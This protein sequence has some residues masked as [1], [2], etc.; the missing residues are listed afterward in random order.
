MD[1]AHR[2]VYRHMKQAGVFEAPPAMLKTISE[3]VTEVYAGQ[4]LADLEPR[5]EMERE[6]EV[7]VER[8]KKEM[9]AA[10]ASLERDI[11]KLREGKTV[12]YRMWERPSSIFGAPSYIG[13]RRIP[14]TYRD[15]SEPR[16]RQMTDN[17]LPHYLPMYEVGEGYK[18]LDFLVNYSVPGQTGTAEEVADYVRRHIEHQMEY[19]DDLDLSFKKDQEGLSQSG[20]V[21]LLLLQKECHKYTSTAKEYATQAYEFFP[22]D[23]TG[24]KYL[25]ELKRHYSTSVFESTLK[26]KRWDKIKVVLNFKPH[27]TSEGMWR[28]RSRTIRV[29]VQSLSFV[30]RRY[31]EKGTAVKSFRWALDEVL[32]TLRHELQHVGQDIFTS[33]MGLED[34]AGTPSKELTRDIKPSKGRKPHALRE[35]EFYTRLLDEVDY[36]TRMLPKHPLKKY[37]DPRKKDRREF[38][39]NWVTGREFFQMLKQHEPAKWRKAVKEF[40]KALSKRRIEIPGKTR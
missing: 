32:E 1:L 10:L 12:K 34:E 36:F 13:I 8:R 25:K 30:G 37:K 23:F 14:R 9:E 27:K 38:F 2:V 5:L 15:P 24:W 20:M 16:V 22:I 3:W 11:K 40:T 28:P 39:D 19:E 18:K 31:L 33:I 17:P 4:V 26:D 6:R 29:D 7:V 21:E 35:S